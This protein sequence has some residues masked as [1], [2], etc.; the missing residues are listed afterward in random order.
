M[1]LSLQTKSG[2]ATVDFS[3]SDEMVTLDAGDSS[4]ATLGAL[5]QTG[6]GVAPTHEHFSGKKQKVETSYLW[7]VA[8]TPFGPFS[9]SPRLTFAIID[10]AKRNLVFSALNSS[11]AQVS[12]IMGQYAK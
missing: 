11:I 10:A 6:W 12:Q 8:P 5:L 4:R 9:S 2:A 1:V 7:L 3:C